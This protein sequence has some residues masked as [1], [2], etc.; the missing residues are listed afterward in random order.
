MRYCQKDWYIIITDVVNSTE[1]I[2]NGRHKDVGTAGHAAMAVADTL[3]DLDFPM[4]RRQRLRARFI[5]HIQP[6]ARR[7]CQHRANA[8]D[9]RW[10]TVEFVPILLTRGGHE[11]RVLKLG[12]IRG[13][14][15]NYA[16]RFRV[17]KRLEA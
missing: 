5:I 4:S 11:L 7:T 13:F 1:A 6:G 2:E 9:V 12:R 15:S 17:C 14:V 16:H 8:R 3:S 10:I